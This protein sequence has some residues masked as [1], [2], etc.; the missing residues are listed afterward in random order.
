MLFKQEHIPMILNGRKTQTRRNWKRQMVKV[1]GI[2]KVKTQMLSKEYYCKIKVTKVWKQKLGKMRASIYE[3][4]D[5]LQEYIDIWTK[6][7][8]SWNPEMEVYVI[9]FEVVK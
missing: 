1:D 2:Y 3:G 9:D 6:I 5:T 8:G 7:N 4:Y